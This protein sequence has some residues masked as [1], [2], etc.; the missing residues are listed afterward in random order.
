V[1]G[2]FIFGGQVMTQ[3]IV[4]NSAHEGGI[5][6]W[7]ESSSDYYAQTFKATGRL[8]RIEIKID[9]NEAPVDYTIIV[10]KYTVVDD[11]LRVTEILYES[12]L[13]TLPGDEEDVYVTVVHDTGGIELTPGESYIFITNAPAGALDDNDSAYSFGYNGTYADGDFYYLNSDEGSTEKDFEQAF[14]FYG[15]DIA[16]RLA[17]ETPPTD[18][19]ETI[20]GTPGDDTINALGGNDIVNAL[21]GTDTVNGGDGDDTLNGDGGDDILK[22]D[23]G[24]DTLNGGA[25]D[26]IAFFGTGQYDDGDRVDGGEGSDTL[27]LRGNYTVDFTQE[28]YAG[29]LSNTETLVVSSASD[30]RFASGGGTEFDYSITWN[31]DLLAAGG[32]MTIDGS[33]LGEEESL[34]FNG[35][36]ETDGRFVLNGGS[37]ND[38]LTGGSGDDIIFGGARGDT[39]TGGA[40]NDI[41]VYRKA[42]DSNSTERDGIQ[43]FNLGDLIDISMIDANTLIEGDQAFDFIGSKRFTNTAGELRFENISLGGPVWI[44]QG[45]TDGNGQSDFEVVLVIFPAD[46]I[47]YSDFIDTIFGAPIANDDTASTNEVTAVDGNVKANDIDQEGDTFSVTA[48]NADSTKV[49]QQITL[50]SGALL[51][52]NANGTYTYD[53]NGAFASLVSAEKAASTGAVN[54][55]GTDTFT[56]TITNGDT[57]TVTVTIDGRDGAGDVLRGSSDDNVITGTPQGDQFDLSSGGTDNV[58]GLAGD[59]AFYFGAAL[60]ADDRVNGGSGTDL[61]QLQGDYSGG[62]TLGADT[63]L[64]VERIRLLSGSLESADTRYAYN[65]TTND[66]NVAAGETLTVLATSLLAGE[67]LL[68]NGTAETDGAFRIQGGAGADILASGAKNDLLQGGAGDDQLYGLGGND[69]LIGGLGTDLLRG[70]A[71]RDTFRF[72]SVEDSTVA[73]PDT[74][75]DFNKGF[76][77]IDLSRIDANTEN[78]VEDAFT[79]VGDAAFTGTAG[80][81]RSVFDASTGQNRVEGDVNGDGFVDFVILVNVPNSA[82]LV[83][84]D[85]I[86]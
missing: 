37:G 5:S 33:L 65:I 57:A 49:G 76:D 56:Y 55:I 47:T 14:T 8:D 69:A 24:N 48:V 30:E 38:V 27:I 53:P 54:S 68:F 66:N 32:T 28:G 40:G 34:A 78:G 23:S 39:L 61:I 2:D 82:P 58:S 59:D 64:G 85:F 3:S 79:F 63:V 67:A 35:S 31:D 74:V 46:P 45:D 22:G 73:A 77:K 9:Q 21:D 84:T 75:V 72:D 20:T 36:D 29:A 51:T 10:A 18:E 50:P 62:L 19:G 13:L 1:F 71:G 7:G 80:E 43:D 16:F 4:D 17:F 86:L 25:G 11:Q 83:V 6:S 52:L 42:S 12:V 44:V 41:F 15:G 26:D 60:T 70:G 81:L